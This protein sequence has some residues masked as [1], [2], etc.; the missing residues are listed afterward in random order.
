MP[1]RGKMAAKATKIVVKKEIAARADDDAAEAGEMTHRERILR[2]E[3]NVVGQEAHGVGSEDVMY[4]TIETNL[5]RERFKSDPAGVR[6]MAEGN[7][8]SCRYDQNLLAAEWLNANCREPGEK[9][10]YERW[11]EIRGGRVVLI[12][13]VQETGC[14]TECWCMCVGTETVDDLLAMPIDVHPTGRT[15]KPARG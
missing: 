1:Y 9:C 7:S 3:G 11:F 5:P 4:F 13:K 12:D 6:I 8:V 14:W 10:W 15:I 2:A